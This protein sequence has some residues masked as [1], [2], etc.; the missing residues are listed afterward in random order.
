MK[1]SITQHEMLD[2]LE[3]QEPVAVLRN[4]ISRQEADEIVNRGLEKNGPMM[5]LAETL[6]HAAQFKREKVSAE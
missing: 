5:N 2:L 6:A 3:S 1:G 4:S